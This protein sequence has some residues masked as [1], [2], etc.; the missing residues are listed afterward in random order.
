MFLCIAL[1]AWLNLHV[2]ISR[3]NAGIFLKALQ[4]IISTTINLIFGILHQAGFEILA[5]I[6]DI[7]TD[8]QTVYKEYKLEPE[9]IRTPSCPTCYKPYLLEDLPDVCNWR[10]SPRSW[11][12]GTELTSMTRKPKRG[13]PKWFPSVHTLRNPLNPSSDFSLHGHRLKSIWRGLFNRNR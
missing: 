7:P 8:I 1:A 3:Q 13:R 9:I 4:L 6:I 12:C 11:P 10:K 2:G 5:P